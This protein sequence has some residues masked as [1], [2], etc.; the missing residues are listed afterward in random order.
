MQKQ[1]THKV[2]NLKDR[3]IRISFRISKRDLAKIEETV[4]GKSRSEKIEKAI[5]S[6]YDIITKKVN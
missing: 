2:K 1:F 4:E 6:G 5:Q 3:K